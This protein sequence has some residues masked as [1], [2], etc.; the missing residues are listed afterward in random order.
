MGVDEYDYA[1]VDDEA[2]LAEAAQQLNAAHSRDA[3]TKAL[4][5]A[6]QVLE[7]CAQSEAMQKAVKPL[8]DELL[9]PNLLTSK[10]KGIRI[11]VAACF[12][13]SLRISAP[14]TPYEDTAMESLFG[15][16]LQVFELL[17]E[18]SAASYRLCVAVLSVFA[19]VKCGLLLWDLDNG[20]M[21][22]QLFRTLLY[23]INPRNKDELYGHIMEI[24][25]YMVEEADEIPPGLIEVLLECVETPEASPPRT[26]VVQSLLKRHEITMRVPL[27]IALKSV[28]EAGG[29]PYHNHYNLLL[30]IHQAVPQLLLPVLPH[31]C[32]LLE[33]EEESK[34]L[35]AVEVTGHLFSHA[36]PDIAGEYPELLSFFL[37][38]FLD[39]KVDVRLRSLSFAKG[40][41]NSCS[42]LDQRTQV[43]QATA[44]R[45]MDIDDRL[46]AHA[47]S[48]VC[49]I[50]AQHQSLLTPETF[51]T[52]L[53]RL[54][55]AKASVR[56]AAGPALAGLFRSSVQS[57]ADGTAADIS[58]S[59]LRIP[60]ALLVHTCCDPDKSV[61]SS[62][63]CLLEDGL[64][65]A[66][67]PPADAAR[68]WAEIIAVT[69]QPG[70]R[71]LTTFLNRKQAFHENVLALLRLRQSLHC[72]PSA[73]AAGLDSAPGANVIQRLAASLPDPP[74]AVEALKKLLALKDNHIFRGLESLEKGSCSP[75]AFETTSSDVLKR[76]GSRGGARDVTAVI[77]RRLRCSPLSASHLKALI[78]LVSDTEAPAGDPAVQAALSLLSIAVSADPRMASGLLEPL[79]GL[80][81]LGGPEVVSFGCMALACVGQKAVAGGGRLSLKAAAI[82]RAVS[83]LTHICSEGPPGA[84]K[85]AGKALAMMAQHAGA[86]VKPQAVVQE[87]VKLMDGGD[88]ERSLAVL[89][90]LSG[91]ARVA[92]EAF[93]PSASHVVELVMC[94]LLMTPEDS[95]PPRSSRRRKSVE[96]WNH[97]SPELAMKGEAINLLGRAMTPDKDTPSGLESM[98]GVVAGLI[99]QLDSILEP[100]N[101]MEAYSI[102][103]DAAEGRIR[104]SAASAMLRLARR[105]HQLFLP[106]TYINL[107][108]TA[109]D[110]VMEVRTSFIAHVV[111]TAGHF[112][113]RRLNSIASK[114]MAMLC[115]S[116]VDP[117]AA[118]RNRAAEE[119]RRF[120]ASRRQAVHAAS[121]A[122]VCS[123]AETGGCN[124]PDQPE[125]MLPYAVFLLAH[126]PDL[127]EELDSLHGLQPWEQMLG[128]I[129][130]P[131]LDHEGLA[132]HGSSL[133]AICKTLLTLKL[134]GDVLAEGVND[135]ICLISDLGLAIVRGAVRSELDGYCSLDVWL[136]LTSVSGCVDSV[137]VWSGSASFL[138]SLPRFPFPGLCTNQ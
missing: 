126:H 87:L 74:R 46:R 106:Q 49:E 75:E 73:S 113:A 3:T 57:I 124:L 72:Q 50:G 112:E 52:A 47:V 7:G 22:D 30:A 92:P 21:V 9:S 80:L 5:R 96:G 122:A 13:H 25:T 115:L 59:V 15:Q 51:K 81:D 121:M 107:S 76:V 83:R 102:R 119:L 12:V 14:L 24:L 129:L 98:H 61:R 58:D 128:F 104:L 116:A 68:I 44:A 66:K 48:V 34:R 109:Q 77:V 67:M 8:A 88:W 43:F 27:Q 31:L 20:S 108:L 18:P 35:A 138:L 103:G 10:D 90:S 70:R 39:Q 93:A 64:F 54:L 82:R 130:E 32:P 71:A 29:G 4:K 53:G 41:C 135:N 89:R 132:E 84:G 33:A 136:V 133:P 1:S 114:Y 120:V 97:P 28:I 65:P 23:S 17:L 40:I 91:F 2:S 38:R 100:S 78:D 118:N 127:T 131:L 69:D 134:S 55:D 117:A 42:S 95:P 111:K 36:E 94:V 63:E 16:V 37:R 123:S 26:R 101:S 6:V 86:E 56:K 79:V 99:Q 85:F 45:Q 11:Y 125:F 60:G 105:H 62:H 19:K 110:P 137:E